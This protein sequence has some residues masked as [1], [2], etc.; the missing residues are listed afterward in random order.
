MPVGIRSSSAVGR[1]DRSG[2][3]SPSG[4]CPVGI[5]A[6][7]EPAPLDLH[8]HTRGEQAGLTDL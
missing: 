1:E 4:G 7:E 5:Q 8:V 6:K 2:K 3:V